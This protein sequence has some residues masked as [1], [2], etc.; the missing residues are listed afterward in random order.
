MKLINRL[1]VS[2][3]TIILL[4]ALAGCRSM[5]TT[6]YSKPGTITI[7]LNRHADRDLL[8]SELNEKGLAGAEALVET[9]GD[10]P[11]TAIIALIPSAILIPPSPWQSTW[12]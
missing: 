10:M 8:A 9:I 4:G 6:T 12:E 11:I 2:G 3:V 7:I 1:L 5:A